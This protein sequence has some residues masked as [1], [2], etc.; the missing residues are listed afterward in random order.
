MVVK[1]LASFDAARFRDILKEKLGN[2]AVFDQFFNFKKSLEGLQDST[3]TVDIFAHDIKK[4]LDTF[5]TQQLAKQAEQDQR[6]AALEA[7][8]N[9][10]FPG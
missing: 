8:P 4:D 9:P 1:E 3:E 6:L 2:Y 10:P 7:Q 5:R